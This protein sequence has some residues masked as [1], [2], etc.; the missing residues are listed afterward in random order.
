MLRSADFL[1]ILPILYHLMSRGTS[2]QAV[3]TVATRGPSALR[4]P[5]DAP[6]RRAGGGTG[7]TPWMR[8]R[9][10]RAMRNPRDILLQHA[11]KG[12]ARSCEHRMPWPAI[13]AVCKGSLPSLSLASAEE[14]AA[15]RI[16]AISAWP[17]SQATKRAVCP[18][19]QFCNMRFYCRCSRSGKARHNFARYI[20]Y[21]WKGTK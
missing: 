12:T 19:E 7:E 5:R 21:R 14:P 15:I 8:T 9:K 2:T 4:S 17:A 16:E 10:L 13:A 3:P 1:S 18:L 20:L 11:G 6:L